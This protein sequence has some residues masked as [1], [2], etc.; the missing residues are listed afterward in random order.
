MRAHLAAAKVA[1]VPPGTA[2]RP[3]VDSRQGR[4]AAPSAARPN[5]RKDPEVIAGGVLLAAA[6]VVGL[7]TARDYGITADEFVFDAAGSKALAWYASGFADRS[8]FDYYDTYLY[9]PWFQILVAA[10]Q[11]LHLVDPFAVRHALT[12][13][14]GL[15]GLA[16]L[17][18]I[19]RLAIG[20]W[21]GLAALVLCLTTGN[22]YGHLFFTP[23]DVP[24]LAAM[25]WATLAVI[26]MAKRAT[27]PSTIAAGLAIG[28]A[29]AT[30]FGGVLAA[31]YLVG[32]MALT[33]LETA[34]AS[35]SGAPPPSAAGRPT[36]AAIAL[37]TL[38]ALLVAAVVA[39][40]LWPWLQI[41]NP[42]RQF[43]DAYDYFIRSYVQFDFPAWGATVASGALPWHYIPGQLLARLPEGFVALIAIA[44]LF[45]AVAIGR[46]VGGCRARIRRDGA[47]GVAACA[48]QLAQA[49]AAL[50]V[51]AAALG[52]PLFVIARG[53]VIFDGLRHLLFVLPMLALL[54]GFGL[55]Q[56]LPLLRRL[57]AYAVA[58]AV[59]YVVPAVS[60]LIYLHPLEYVAMSGFAGGVAGAADRFDL[61]YWSA[62]ATEAARRLQARR[63]R[64]P[65]AL[66]PARAPR[67][68]VCIPYRETMAAPLFPPPWIVVGEP[69]A[70]DY[71]IE[72]ERSRCG[73]DAAGNVIDTVQ[74]FGVTFAR[75]IEL[76][77]PA[78]GERP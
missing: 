6:L 10:A 2:P 35:A 27:W 41:A 32:A 24:F 34:A 26:V 55:L 44:A 29:V 28:L 43:L 60:T 58:L 62:A 39:I 71:L 48:L 16:A 65:Q 30:R 64:E 72:T 25:T 23:N 14:V 42:L 15:A 46:F 73:R 74:R 21:A 5:A 56:L 70:A 75:T 8:L 3:L 45:G 36:L 19:G 33:A 61:D 17:I 31:A 1:R 53:S 67:V 20:P 47:A 4:S 38:A 59:L 52:P 11:A 78:I 18:P 68:L 50:V 51:I 22:L 7:L 37:R 13:V 12:F 9:G 40:A 69:E 77:Q 76:P 57:P 63:D 49:R 54:A 66:R